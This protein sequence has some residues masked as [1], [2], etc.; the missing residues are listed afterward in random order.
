MKN[1]S[2]KNVLAL[3]IALIGSPSAMLAQEPFS[4]SCN[5]NGNISEQVYTSSV[6]VSLNHS[7]M[8]ITGGVPP[9]TYQVPPSQ[10]ATESAS[11]PPE[12][13][14]T[15]P[16]GL[17]LS[18]NGVITGTPITTGDFSVEVTDADT[19]YSWCAI[20]I[21][22]PSVYQCV[23]PPSGTAIPGAAVSW[24]QF[25]PVG[26]TDVVWINA[27]IGTPSG[28]PTNQVTTVRFTGVTFVLNGVTYNLPDGFL[29][30][31]PSAP[32]TPTTTYTP[33]PGEPSDL[34]A[35]YG[36][37]TTTL[38]PSNLSDE[39]FFDGQAVPVNSNISGGGGA[40]FNFTS[41]STDTSL[42]FN[43]QWSAA[44]Y[45]YW[46]NNNA[47]EILP[48]HDSLHAGTPQNPAVQQSLIQGPRGGGG[49]NY[50]G[51]WSGTGQ[52]VCPQ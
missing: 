49:S 24:N 10:C 2:Q 26:S 38:N 51:S 46:P 23:I 36:S 17:T 33:P 8:T 47:A 9:F 41:D 12:T 50:T 21:V 13:C 19:Y 44:V 35:P 39:I 4:V 48:Y 31:D 45:T 1:R 18:S 32:A 3:A 20:D 43:W 16:P 14:N 27:H 28:I 37:W 40:T 7:V 52:G 22:P 6:G 34:Y 42:D 15:M 11:L 29:I 5:A 25:N 30:F